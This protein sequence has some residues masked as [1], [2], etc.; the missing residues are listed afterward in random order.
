MFSSLVLKTKVSL[1]H[2]WEIS[3]II[4]C[5]CVLKQKGPAVKIQ[6]GLG[7]NLSYLISDYAWLSTSAKR[8]TA[9]VNSSGLAL[10]KFKRSAAFASS[11][12]G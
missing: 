6:Q 11:A 4:V 10:V 1:H 5:L 7:I 2:G 3:G 12:F 9:S 8:F